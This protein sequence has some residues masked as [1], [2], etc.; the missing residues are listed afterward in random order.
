MCDEEEKGRSLRFWRVLVGHPQF[1]SASSK[2]SAHPRSSSIL[3]QSFVVADERVLSRDDGKD[4][5]VDRKGS[6]G[7]YRDLKADPACTAS[8]GICQQREQRRT[9]LSGTATPRVVLVLLTR[10]AL[11]LSPYRLLRS[12]SLRY[13][14]ST[15]DD[16]QQPPATAAAAEYPPAQ[17]ARRNF[18]V[19]ASFTL[20]THPARSSR[21]RQAPRTRNTRTL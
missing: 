15:L 16:H 9:R 14:C 17:L 20:T 7:W 6:P 4:A 3:W 19:P 12:F 8:P 21:S 11:P 10:F 1:A 13:H 5:N 18:P 2:P